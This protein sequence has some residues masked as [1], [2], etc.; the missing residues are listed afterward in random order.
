M[1]RKLV[2]ELLNTSVEYQDDEVETAS[3]KDL[4]ATDSGLSQEEALQ[5]LHRE[6]GV[7]PV[8]THPEAPEKLEEL[9][10]EGTI[11]YLDGDRVWVI[12]E[13]GNFR[14]GYGYKGYAEERILL[15]D[16]KLRD[17]GIL[18]KERLSLTHGVWS[19]D[20]RVGD[21]IVFKARVENGGLKNPTNV[22]L[23]ESS[24][25]PPRQRGGTQGSGDR[26]IQLEMF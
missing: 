8:G 4:R 7:Q 19:R 10:S 14:P 21:V 16:V 26:G 15:K 3:P 20:L 17:F 5:R 9:A 18:L 24:P 13:V 2:N 1:K 6:V 12:A 11:K 23:I 22:R 25:R